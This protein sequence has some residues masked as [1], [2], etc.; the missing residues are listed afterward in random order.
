AILGKQGGVDIDVAEGRK[1]DHPLGDDAT[2]GDDDDGVRLNRFQ[3]RTKVG[4]DL[5]LLR[6]H[7]RDSVLERDLLYG[8]RDH[9]E[10]AALGTIRLGNDELHVEACLQQSFETGNC[11][12]RRSAE[13][14]FHR[15]NG[16]GVSL[17]DESWLFPLAGFHQLADLALDEIALEAADVADVKLAVEVIGFVQEGAREQVLTGHLE[18][19][20]IDVLCLDGDFF[21]TRDVFAELRKTQT[22]FGRGLTTFSLDDLRIG[23]NDFGLGIFLEGDVYDGEMQGDADLRCGQ[24]DAMGFVHRFEHIV[25]ELFELAIKFSYGSGGR[26]E[27]GIAKLHYGIDHQ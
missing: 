6:L 7:Y 3:L 25:D 22:A 26:F 15:V 19:F 13:D 8:G 5:D 2:I 16:T 24:A 10:T 21:R 18:P 14:Q 11:K 12:R 1:V 4:I 23:E 20:A 27:Y 9:F 17:S